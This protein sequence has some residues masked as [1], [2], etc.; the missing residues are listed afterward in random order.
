MDIKYTSY[1]G[2]MYEVITT[3]G[4]YMWTYSTGTTTMLSATC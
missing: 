4:R 1:I 2:L 3:I